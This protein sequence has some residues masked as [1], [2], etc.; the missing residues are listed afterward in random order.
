VQPSPRRLGR[1]EVVS[2]LAHGGMAELFLAHLPGIEG[3]ARKVVI[4]RVLPELA[5]DR[6]F[7]EMFLEE[8]RLAATLHHQNI[9][10]VYDIDHDEGGYFFAMEHLHGADVGELLRATD[11]DVPLPIALEI[12]R[13]ACAGLH[14]AHE[15]KGASGPLGIVHRD[16]S[17][18]NIF[19]TF[20]GGVKLLD[21][22][23]AKAVQQSPSHYTRSGTL[24]GKLPY[25]SPEQ[26]RG[27]AIDRRSDAFSLAVVLWEMTVGERL[28]GARR[29]S[30]FEILK[31][32]VEADAPRPSSRKPGYPPALEA[33]VMK[34]LARERDRR[35]QTCDELQGE[36][37]ALIRAGG[38]WVTARD[39][40]QYLTGRFAERAASS[41][42]LVAAEA[43]AAGGEIVPFPRATR[44][45]P[46]PP[47]ATID[48]PKPRHAP[49]PGGPRAVA[50]PSAAAVAPIADAGSAPVVGPP[51]A[52]VASPSSPVAA[53]HPAPGG[54]VPPGSG[55]AI[56]P[57]AGGGF[58][59]ASSDAHAPAPRSRVAV[60]LAI[61]V[62]VA[63]VA[64]AVGVVL[65]RRLGPATG[66]EP[67]VAP[68]AAPASSPASA[69][70]RGSPAAPSVMAG[71]GLAGAPP[72]VRGSELGPGVEVSGTLEAS[73]V[74]RHPFT[75][76]AGRYFVDL[77]VKAP[78]PPEPGC[79]SQPK[80]SMT[81]I[82]RDEA[83]VGDAFTEG[84][85][86][87]DNWEKKRGSYDLS[88]AYQAN[89]RAGE[90]RVLYRLHVVSSAP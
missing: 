28:F 9:V 87:R 8:A 2:L 15:R 4:K 84:T 88:G 39:L 44:V 67:S 55:P 75:V 22:G 76:P 79:G 65:G 71:S 54:G 17:P 48:L 59:A 58:T 82:D 50:V 6:D 37:E 41:M 56:A 43:A 13:G 69:S 89:V 3:F 26:C 85:W 33:I 1:Y 80:V 52:A 29:E 53:A 66:G 36:L 16:V 25:M 61:A 78:D 51:V 49:P 81:V 31:S 57:G 23:I 63:A 90:C 34:G 64:L 10:A 32:I 42:Q 18:Q 83:R 73:G 60:V 12:A 40:A 7:V 86:D 27:A 74:R 45:V 19:V 38:L 11:G 47:S 72:I 24:R 5:R 20:D 77:F 62:A 70:S 35:H 46:A 30:E 21:F 68:G 14:H